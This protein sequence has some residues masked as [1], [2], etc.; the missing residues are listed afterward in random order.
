MVSARCIASLIPGNHPS[1]REKGLVTIARFLVC[2][3]LSSL[4]LCKP[5]RSLVYVCLMTRDI[6]KNV[7][8]L[9][10]ASP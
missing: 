8:D 9:S 6:T 10:T 4:V 2:A 1:A 3:E 7:C 5:M